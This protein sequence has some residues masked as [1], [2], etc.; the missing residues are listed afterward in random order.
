M[1]LHVLYGIEIRDLNFQSFYDTMADLSFQN[2]NNMQTTKTRTK[3][4]S[5]V[6]LDNEMKTKIIA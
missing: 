6:W 3:R 4:N 2:A 5:T 1:V